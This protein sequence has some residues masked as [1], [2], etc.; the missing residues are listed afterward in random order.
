V[1]RG[2]KAL[3]TAPRRGGKERLGSNRGCWTRYKVLTESGR[4]RCAREE[5]EAVVGKKRARGP[6]VKARQPTKIH[7]GLTIGQGLAKRFRGD[8][9]KTENFDHK[10]LRKGVGN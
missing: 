1:G 4:R 2:K 3:G 8:L 7:G 9:G 6:G 5:L 10:A